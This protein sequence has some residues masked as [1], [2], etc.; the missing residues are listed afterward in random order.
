MLQLRYV[1]IPH[2]GLEIPGICLCGDTESTV[3][4]PVSSAA[5]DHPRALRQWENLCR[6]AL[7]RGQRRHAH[8]L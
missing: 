8:T 3:H 4:T 2:S 5:V 7:G 6:P 1:G